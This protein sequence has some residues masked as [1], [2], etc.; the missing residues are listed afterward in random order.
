MGL[1]YFCCSIFDNT[2]H[3]FR[4]SGTFNKMVAIYW[5]SAVF[6]KQKTQCE[7]PKN[8]LGFSNTFLPF[9]LLLS[10]LILSF[11]LVVTEN[12]LFI[13]GIRPPKTKTIGVKSNINHGFMELKNIKHAL[14]VLSE[15]YHNEKYSLL[16]IN[17]AHT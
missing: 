2:F 8:Q 16:H 7:S 15:Q 17:H 14:I 10:S 4:E 9:A 5:D 6:I 1:N 11:L 13:T 12:L 3:N